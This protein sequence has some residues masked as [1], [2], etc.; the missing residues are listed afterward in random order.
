MW[1]AE[2]MAD[3]RENA[4]LAAL[5]APLADALADA[6]ETIL[7]DLIDCQGV[8][9]DIGGY[10]FPDPALASRAMRPSATFNTIIDQFGS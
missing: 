6:E 10:Y 8:P 5:F 4:E 9:M 3:Q 2:A 1:W 7:Q